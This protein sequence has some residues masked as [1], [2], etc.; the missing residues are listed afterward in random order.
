MRRWVFSCVTIFNDC[1]M[2]RVQSTGEVIKSR[3]WGLR[4]LT[5]PCTPAAELN[6]GAFLY[7]SKSRC[8]GNKGSLSSLQAV[9]TD[10]GWEKRGA[11]SILFLLLWEENK[12]EYQ[13]PLIALHSFFLCISLCAW[14]CSHNN[15]ALTVCYRGFLCV[16][17]K[18]NMNFPCLH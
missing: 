1:I 16:H 10:C 17:N 11:I 12:L 5:P 8:T 13:S 15:P 3:R 2:L 7:C 6:K 9:W 4:F 14:V 18:G